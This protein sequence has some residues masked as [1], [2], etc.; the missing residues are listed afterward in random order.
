MCLCVRC[1]YALFHE[2]HTVVPGSLLSTLITS[3]KL[4]YVPCIV[5]W[6][7][8][9][10]NRITRPFRLKTMQLCA[11]RIWLYAGIHTNSKGQVLDMKLLVCDLIFWNP[12]TSSE[13]GII[14]KW[15][16]MLEI[17]LL[18]ASRNLEGRRSDWMALSELSCFGVNG[19]HFAHVQFLGFKTIKKQAKEKLL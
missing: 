2:W 10:C 16:I 11:L 15:N 14:H 7:P 19:N 12:T 6:S 13:H 3:L 9:I 18:L 17:K 1:F 4:L 5:I 8:Y